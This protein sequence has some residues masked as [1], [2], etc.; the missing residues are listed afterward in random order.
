MLKGAKLILSIFLVFLNTKYLWFSFFNGYGF[1][2]P[3]L[4]KNNSFVGRSFWPGHVSR[5]SKQVI[6]ATSILNI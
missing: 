2:H 1:P 5:T 4:F 6:Y 3:I